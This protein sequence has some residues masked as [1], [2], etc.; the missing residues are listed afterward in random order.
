[1]TSS[2]SLQGNRTAYIALLF[3][4]IGVALS[5]ALFLFS[6][7]NLKI[8]YVRTTEL[9][10]GFSGMRE[11]HDVYEKKRQSSQV[12]LDSMNA[13]YQKALSSYST[14][15]VS[16]SEPVRREREDFLRTQ[17]DHLREQSAALD[18]Q[19]RDEDQRMT[20]G[21]LNQINSMTQ[22]YGREHGFDLILATTQSGSILYGAQAI[23]LT[24]EL[25]V[26]INQKYNP[27]APQHDSSH[28]QQKQ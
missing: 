4:I 28:D 20:Q 21:V 10:Y 18:A 25:L 24:E 3:G 8:G 12:F 11:A 2:K 14:E 16:L 19:I 26:V 1:M 7:R 15:R 13:D 23:D 6:D 22:D 9:V 27:A 5:V 17:Q